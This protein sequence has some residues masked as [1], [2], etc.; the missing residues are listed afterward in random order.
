MGIKE[1]FSKIPNFSNTGLSDR[2]R[3]WLIK[4]VAGKHA[5]VLNVRI[6]LVSRQDYPGCGARVKDMNG[7]LVDTVIFPDYDGKII[8]LSGL[9][10]DS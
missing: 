4:K 1:V 6:D 8:Q 2:I 3:H 7:C 9:D 10:H 5:V